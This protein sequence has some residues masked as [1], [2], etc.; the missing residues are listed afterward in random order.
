MLGVVYVNLNT[1]G[2]IWRNKSGTSH[3]PTRPE[4]GR[5]GVCEVPDLLRQIEPCVF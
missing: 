5:V 1:Q 2:S 3:T 4:S